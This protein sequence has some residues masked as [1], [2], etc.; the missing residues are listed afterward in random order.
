MSSENDSIELLRGMPVFGGLADSALCFLLEQSQTLE[1]AAGQR[2][3]REGDTAE[4]MFVLTAGSVRIEKEFNGE[5]VEIRKLVVGDCFGEMAI[6][7]LQSRSASVSAVVN[8]EAIEV[9]RA[10]LHHLY[11]DDVQQYAIIMMNMGRE[12]SRR[13]RIASDR[14]FAFDQSTLY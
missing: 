7:D 10:T 8:C 14:L 2:F 11:Q 5:P 13:L 9:T 1:V 4:S 12:V 6:I 3:F